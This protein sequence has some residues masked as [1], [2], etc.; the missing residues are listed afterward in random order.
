M[1]RGLRVPHYELIRDNKWGRL[2]EKF[3]YFTPI[4]GYDVKVN[5]A[6]ISFRLFENGMLEVYPDTE[7]DFGTGA[8]DTPAMVLASLAHDM[9]C[10][11][12]N[13]GLLPWKERHNA[14]KYFGKLLD[15]AG[16]GLSRLWRIPLVMLN[17]QT[18]A[19]WRAKEYEHTV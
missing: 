6:R 3:V 12:T 4:K 9:F 10:Y 8:V 17:S 2:L 13:N 7:W 16:A 5:H 19:R 14:D 15:K 1:S 18:I 11:M